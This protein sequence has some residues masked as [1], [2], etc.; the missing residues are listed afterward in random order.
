[1]NNL[2]IHFGGVKIKESSYYIVKIEK[3]IMRYVYMK[4]LA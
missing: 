1:M 2:F 3:I 4:R